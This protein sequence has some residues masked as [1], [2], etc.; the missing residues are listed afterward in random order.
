MIENIRYHKTSASRGDVVRAAEAVGA[1]E[2]IMALPDG[3]DTRLEQRGGNLS[4]GQRQLISFAR[5]IV[6]DA[7]ILVLDEA[8]S[9]VDTESERRIQ[10]GIDVVLKGRIS[11]IIAHRLSTIRAADRILVIDHGQIVASANKSAVGVIPLLASPQGGVAARP[12]IIA[13]HP[14]IAWTGGLSDPNEK[15]NHPGCVRFGGYA[16]FS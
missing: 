10:R 12:G 5:A 2:F 9:S 14:M 13:K 8:T 3:Y 16:T 7:K 11:V 4:L 6:A 1:H 15:E